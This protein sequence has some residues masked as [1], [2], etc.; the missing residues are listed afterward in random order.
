LLILVEFFT[1]TDRNFLFIND[2]D[3]FPDGKQYHSIKVDGRLEL[4]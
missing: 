3:F 2:S 1:I 4:S